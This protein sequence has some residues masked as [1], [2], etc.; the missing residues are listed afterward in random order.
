MTT[1]ILTQFIRSTEAK[2]VIVKGVGYSATNFGVSGKQGHAQKNEIGV[3]MSDTPTHQWT[4][5]YVF[6]M[7]AIGSAVG[8]ANIWKFPY[9]VGTQ[10]GGAFILIYLLAVFVIAVPI[11]IA[12]LA[13]GRSGR[14]GPATSIEQVALASGASKNWK[15]IA[16][17]GILASILALS[18]YFT[19]SGWAVFYTL[20][21]LRGSFVDVQGADFQRIYDDF[22]QSPS[23]LI[24]YMTGFALMTAIP[25]GLGVTNG[26]ERFVKSVMPVF[27]VLLIFTCGVA[28]LHGDLSATVDF[29]FRFDF[30]AITGQTILYAIGQAFFSVGVGAC[31]L[32][33]FGSYLPRNVS[34]VKSAF[35]IAS[36]DTLI[37]LLSGLTI[38]PIVFAQGLDPGEGPGLMF[39]ALPAALSTFYMG[40]V[41]ATLFFT[42]LLLAALTSAIAI[43]LPPIEWLKARFSLSHI[44]ATTLVFSFEWLLAITVALSFNEWSD[45]YPLEFIP[46]FRDLTFFGIYEMVAANI[47]MPLGGVLLS[48][49]V[50]W[51]MSSSI[52]REELNLKSD[53]SVILWRGVFRYLIPL[54][55][56]GMATASFSR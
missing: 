45:F 12:E 49:F 8:L 28:M 51:G 5:N 7:A 27:F 54:A 32:I 24:S 29:M 34:I 42:M 55:L 18:F 1:N 31:V 35:I 52:L 22:T 56:L 23:E 43:A 13:I 50:G 41:L 11:L 36:V 2:L 47:A 40:S 39:V 48:L 21:S 53:R 14:R 6:L 37:A 17:F 3:T 9:T 19:I 10:G 25:V 4:S 38:F 33:V 30:E 26:I 46:L 44:V 16:F 15:H 20:E